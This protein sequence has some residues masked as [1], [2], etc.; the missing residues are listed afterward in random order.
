MPVKSVFKDRV[1]GLFSAKPGASFSQSEIE[2]W[3]KGEVKGPVIGYW[4]K[5][6]MKDGSLKKASYGRYQLN[7]KPPDIVAI[8]KLVQE[9]GAKTIIDS[10]RL[11]KPGEEALML[12]T[13]HP[14]LPSRRLHFLSI[15]ERMSKAPAFSEY[16]IELLKSEAAHLVET[17]KTP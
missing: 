15:L 3:L 5:Q 12:H 9:T 6:F 17:V 2:K 11:W 7:D 10:G 13:Q 16:D 1:Y 8:R 4:I 14:T